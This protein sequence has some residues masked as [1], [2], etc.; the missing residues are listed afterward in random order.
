MMQNCN[1]W[2]DNLSAQKGEQEVLFPSGSFFKITAVKRNKKTHHQRVEIWMEIPQYYIEM[3]DK[4]L[5]KKDQ[6]GQPKDLKKKR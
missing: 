5:P 2:M 1:V 4:E 6:K 3:P